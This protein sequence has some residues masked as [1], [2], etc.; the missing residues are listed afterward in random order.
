MSCFEN[1]VR[2]VCAWV[3][4]STMCTP[5]CSQD[6]TQDR[7]GEYSL[8]SKYWKIE[9]SLLGKYCKLWVQFVGQILQD[10]S[11]VCWAI[12]ARFEYSLLGKYCKLWVQSVGQILQDL[13]TECW[14]NTEAVPLFYP[15]WNSNDNMDIRLQKSISVQVKVLFGIKSRAAP[16]FLRSLSRLSSG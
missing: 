15:A 14:A 2:A 7:L 10:L 3:L 1:S 8:L 4:Q 5:L 11:T 6:S 16:K 13:S 9:Y 12:T